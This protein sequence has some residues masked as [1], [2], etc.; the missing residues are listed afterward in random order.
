MKNYDEDSNKRYML[1]VYVNYQKQL[2]ELHRNMPFL[3]ER[4]KIDKCQK[5]VCNLYI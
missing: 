3:S 2:H 4:M 1:E 5:L